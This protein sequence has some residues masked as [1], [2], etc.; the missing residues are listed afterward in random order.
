MGHVDFEVGLCMPSV[1]SN[2]PAICMLLVVGNFKG[3]SLK[4]YHCEISKCNYNYNFE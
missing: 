3:V 2:I 4:N 1:T